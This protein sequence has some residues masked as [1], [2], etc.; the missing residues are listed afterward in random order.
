MLNLFQD[1]ISISSDGWRPII[2]SRRQPSEFETEI[3]TPEIT[4]YR[5]PSQTA[6]VDIVKAETSVLSTSTGAPKKLPNKIREAPADTINNNINGGTFHKQGGKIPPHSKFTSPGPYHTIPSSAHGPHIPIGGSHNRPSQFSQIQKRPQIKPTSSHFGQSPKRQPIRVQ[7]TAHSNRDEVFVRP[8]NSASFSFIKQGSSNVKTRETQGLGLPGTNHFSVNQPSAN[9]DFG[10]R[11]A[12]PQSNDNYQQY[13]SHPITY[14][15]SKAPTQANEIHYQFKN[16]NDDYTRNLVPPPLSRFQPEPEKLTKTQAATN[17]NVVAVTEPIIKSIQFG[18]FGNNVQQFGLKPPKPQE[19]FV[20]QSL[21]Q[22]QQNFSFQKLDTKPKEQAIDV[23]VTKEK[24]KVFHSDI[25][26]SY[27]PGIPEYID[28]DFHSVKRPSVLPKLQTYEVTEGKWVDSPNPYTFNYPESQQILPQRLIRLPTA[29]PQ[30]IVEPIVELNVP[31][32]LPTPYKPQGVVPTSPTQSEAS[33]VFSKVSTKMNRFKNEALTTNPLFFDVKEV[34]THYPILGK[35]GPKP[36]SSTNS[37]MSMDAN[38]EISNEITTL[39]Q[40]IEVETTMLPTTIR[41]PQRTKTRRRRP[42]P[43]RPISTSTT[44]EDPP[45]TASY[46]LQKTQENYEEMSVETERPQEDPGQGRTVIEPAVALIVRRSRLVTDQLPLPVRVRT[47]PKNVSGQGIG[48]GKEVT[49]VKVKF[50]NHLSGNEFGQP[51][52]RCLPTIRRTKMTCQCNPTRLLNPLLNKAT[53]QSKRL[54]VYLKLNILRR[55]SRALT[56]NSPLNLVDWTMIFLKR[57]HEPTQ[58]EE[59]SKFDTTIVNN[60]LINTAQKP[61][62]D[63]TDGVTENTHVYDKTRSSVGSTTVQDTTVSTP[64]STSPENEIDYSTAAPTLE[65]NDEGL[66]TTSATT[67]P[68]TTTTTEVTTTKSHRI[69]GRPTKYDSS[70]R[71]R[72]SVKDYRQRLNQYTSTTPSTTTDFVKTTEG[73]RL[74]FPSRLRTRPTPKTTTQANDQIEE[75]HTEPIRRGGFKPKEPRHSV[76]TTDGPQ[77]NIVTEKNIKSVNTRLRPF[78]RYR[79]TTESTSATP[80]VS[81]KPNLFSARRRPP[82]LTLRNRVFSKFHNNS[83]EETT[84]YGNEVEVTEPVTEETT[85]TEEIP[86]Q[87]S[88][89]FHSKMKIVDTTTE[90]SELTTIDLNEDDYSQRVSELTS[91]FKNEYETPGLFK[92]VS[93]TSRRIPSY[94]TI[95][96]DDPILPIEA[97]FP[98]IK[99]KEKDQ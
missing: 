32:F 92:S 29:R 73:I 40:E 93:P 66:E 80:K 59:E 37:L 4:Q 50:V 3:K 57:Y 28:Y 31:P 13:K 48:T 76:T 20:P 18:D 2:G 42:Q 71:P 23:Q 41:V 89:E 22:F 15:F 44:T 83:T 67:L 95:S 52:R 91:S 74:R 99:E 72:F 5:N 6:E 11:F 64:I 63:E 34:S 60:D 58:Q 87:A 16:Q 98:N 46:E 10:N 85:E 14:I 39:R 27:K 94:F 47:V 70:S 69:R 56:K 62:F 49:A 97:F 88:T 1:A 36:D 17:E 79:F 84:T 24:F 26:N 96:T 43:R 25:P 77:D 12:L 55:V 9:I 78:G 75:E 38:S 51:L 82:Q 8:P 7:A 54:K 90:I 30:L 35:P 53:L 68:T 19:N 61:I 33:T 21:P 81:I 45:P 86:T 65:Q